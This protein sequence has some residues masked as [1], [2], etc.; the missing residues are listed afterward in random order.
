MGEYGGGPGLGQGECV[1]GVEVDEGGRVGVMVFRGIQKSTAG[2][3]GD[4]RSL[5]VWKGCHL[6][7]N[8]K[9]CL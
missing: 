3:P 7:W 5:E 1:A 2:H 8:L 4:W 9:G 6:G